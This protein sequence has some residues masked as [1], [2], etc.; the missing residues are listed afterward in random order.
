MN[1]RALAAMALAF[2]VPGAGHFFLGRR[3]RGAAFFFVVACMFALGLAVDGGL[4]VLR[5]A[6]GQFLTALASLG[7]MG[8]G[9]LYFLAAATGPHGNIRAL[10]FEYGRTF[11]LTAGV[12]N[13]LLVLDCYDLAV[14]RKGE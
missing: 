5:E 10:T 9:S 6:K 4:Y 13:L 7:S 14:G 3:A 1:G 12:M 2:V 8:S 11:T